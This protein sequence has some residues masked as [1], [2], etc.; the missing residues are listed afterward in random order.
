MLPNPSS[1]RSPVHHSTFI[2][3]TLVWQ[4]VN[5]YV[6]FRSQPCLCVMSHIVLQVGADVAHV[7]GPDG[8]PLEIAATKWCARLLEQLGLQGPRANLEVTLGGA[9]HVD[10]RLLAAARICVAQSQAEI[11][12]WAHACV[13]QLF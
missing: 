12:V 4:H 1:H 8:G 9:H 7:K 3:L 6:S 13:V 2:W 11:E 5:C 10:P